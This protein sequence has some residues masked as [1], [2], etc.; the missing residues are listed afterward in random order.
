VVDNGRKDGDPELLCVS[1]INQ[2]VAQWQRD[3]FQ[4]GIASSEEALAIACGLGDPRTEGGR[5]S[6]L[7]VLCAGVGRLEEAAGY[8]ARE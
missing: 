2:A 7:G 1:L 6:R 3:L 4:E 5:L 8:L